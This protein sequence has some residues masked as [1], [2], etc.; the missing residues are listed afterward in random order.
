M[1]DFFKKGLNLPNEDILLSELNTSSAFSPYRADVSS[2]TTIVDAQIHELNNHLGNVLAT[3]SDAK[4]PTGDAGNGQALGYQPRIVNL[5][6]Y[7]PFGMIMPARQFSEEGYRYGFQGQE[8]DDEL[9]GEGNSVNYK[10]RMHDARIGRFLSIDPLA[11]NYPWNSPYAFSENRVIDAVELEGLEKVVVVD[12]YIN[13]LRKQTTITRYSDIEGTIAENGPMGEGTLFISMVYNSG[14]RQYEHKGQ[15]YDQTWSEWAFGVDEWLKGS[16]PEVISREADF[17]E[18]WIIR[19]IDQEAVKELVDARWGKTGVDGANINVV[20]MPGNSRLVEPESANEG[21]DRVASPGSNTEN[22]GS[23]VNTDKAV[24][25]RGSTGVADSIN[26][27]YVQLDSQ[28]VGRMKVPNTA[29]N[30]AK[31]DSAYNNDRTYSKDELQK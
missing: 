16:P 20:S 10:Y 12:F 3:I 28:T 7:F 13:G 22:D 23:A 14:S 21:V 25:K 18:Q 4:T 2:Y 15:S 19:N 5:Q 8:T 31:R 30:R 27:P 9:K 29:A 26:I 6:D 1:M 11:P 17:F 24:Y